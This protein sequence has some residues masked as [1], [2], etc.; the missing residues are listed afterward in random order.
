M[1]TALIAGWVLT[2]LVGLFLIGASGIPKFIDFPGKAEMM[3]HLGLPLNLLPTIGAIE[4]AVAVLYLAPRTSFV[5][6][7]LLTGY[8]GGAT[9]THFRV[10]DTAVFPIV[11]GVLAWIGLALREPLIFALAWRGTCSACAAKAAT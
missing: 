7:I 9:L 11:I 10:G 8:L 3:S 4:I 2:V 1:K 6:A 5:G